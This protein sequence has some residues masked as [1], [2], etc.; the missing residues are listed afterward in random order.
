[1]FT[2][3]CCVENTLPKAVRDGKGFTLFQT[4]GD[5]TIEKL[6]TAACCLASG[7]F[8]EYWIIV[9]EA[10]VTL[11]RFL[12]R[13]F[14][15]GWI[16][17]LHLLTTSD[18]TELVTSELGDQ[19][20][21]K[22]EYGWRE[23]LHTSLFCCVGDRETVVVTGEMLLMPMT[24]SSMM[25]YA[26][27]AGPNDRLIANGGFVGSILE[28]LRAIFNIQRKKSVAE[29]PVSKKKTSKKKNEEAHVSD[30]EIQD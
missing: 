13:W 26:A 12:R 8:G 25:S 7:G 10:D 9:K 15:R 2:E 24:T 14:D 20:T 22:T 29:N 4:N 17:Q 18:Q 28:N 6:M 27:A 3:P 23:D 11:M 21:A 30:E 5:V 19:W 1:M 16:R